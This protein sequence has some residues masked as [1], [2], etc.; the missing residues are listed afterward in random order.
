MNNCV[1]IGIV[2]SIV[3][4]FIINKSNDKKDFSIPLLAGV[5]SWYITEKYIN[6]ENIIDTTSDAFINLTN[7]GL[8]SE[9]LIK[10]LII[11]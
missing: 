5:L 6:I 7:T 1:I 2:M 8:E 9:Q 3:L 11:F 10:E 4:Y